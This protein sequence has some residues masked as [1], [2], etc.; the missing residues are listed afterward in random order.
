MAKVYNMAVKT[1]EY[2]DRNGETKGKYENIG[3]V[4]KG[5]HGSYCLLK[6]TFN[7]AGA[8]NKDGNVLISLFEPKEQGKGDGFSRAPAKPDFDSDVPF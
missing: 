5:E 1:G 3:A 8:P 7:P 4:M 6:T 2:K